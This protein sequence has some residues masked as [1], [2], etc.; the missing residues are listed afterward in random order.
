MAAP[1]QNVCF[2]CLKRQVPLRE[3][4]LPGLSRNVTNDSRGRMSVK[5]SLHFERSFKNSNCIYYDL[6]TP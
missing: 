5:Q 6:I 1:V 2:L 3:I 4:R